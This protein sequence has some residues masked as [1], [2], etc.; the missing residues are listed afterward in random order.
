QACQL[1]SPS[2]RLIFPD[3]QAQTPA[4]E[5]RRWEGSALHIRC[6]YPAQPKYQQQKA[7]CRLTDGQ[8]KPLVETPYDPYSLI[9]RIT[10]ENTTIE[11]TLTRGTMSIIMTNLQAKDSGTYAC[12]YRS[13]RTVYTYEYLPLK[14]ISL[15]VVKEL[16]RWE[17]D[18]VSVQCTYSTVLHS[19]A[20]KGWCRRGPAGCKMW[21][22]TNFPATRSNS[23]ALE[24][25]ASI[26]DDVQKSTLSITMQKL[27]ARDTG[28]Y[29]CVLYKDS[30]PTR[31]MEVRLSVSK[32]SAG[33][34]SPG[35]AGTTPSTPSGN[36]SALSSKVN[37]F[38]LLS[39]VLSILFIL[40]L[41]SSITL[42]VRWRKQ[43]KRRGNREAEDVYEKP[44]DI[45]QLSS[46]ERMETPKDDSKDLKY[47]TLNFKSRFSPKDALYC[48]L[49]LSQAHKKAKE[50]SVD[51][52]II[53]LKHS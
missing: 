50:E 20:T 49:E 16:Q 19:L 44:E 37:I 1:L 41:I 15:S 8:W 17:L 38:I 7:W 34:T 32:T 2:P 42:Y 10:K 31:L 51:Y 48:N 30:Q 3:L 28:T 25:R 6:P 23:K 43:L 40:A 22:K 21:L 27:Q 24:D 29:W 36:T 11:D 47:A 13:Y 12:S 14:T 5:E 35:T 4:V 26:Q 45:A 9:N 18:S 52:A 33:T 39:G 46:T 53:A